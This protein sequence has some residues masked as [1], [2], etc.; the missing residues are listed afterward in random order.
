MAVAATPTVDWKVRIEG[1]S[2]VGAQYIRQPPQSPNSQALIERFI[3]TLQQECLD[4]FIP[5]GTKHLDLLVSETVD[6][7]HEERPHQALDKSILAPLPKAKRKKESKAK[8]P[9]GSTIA[10][11]EVRCKQRLGGLLKYYYRQAA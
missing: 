11:S 9:K 10:L 5:I 7:Y 6:H 4:Y 1:V 2:S 3:Q 8:P